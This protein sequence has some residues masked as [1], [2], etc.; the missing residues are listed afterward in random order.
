MDANER[1]E[2]LAELFYRATGLMAPGKSVPTAM[3]SND[4]E[5]RRQAAWP[6][7]YARFLSYAIVAAESPA[8]LSAPEREAVQQ[9]AIALQRIVE[10]LC[11]A[12]HD[13]PGPLHP[14]SQGKAPHHEEMADLAMT[15]LAAQRNVPA[16]A[17]SS[18]AATAEQRNE[19]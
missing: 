15:A 7:W 1:F 8:P 6:L 2:R 14:D 3:S 17:S 13:Q 16:P 19:R 5:E 10:Q 18:P 12:I 11:E 9:Y 4:Y